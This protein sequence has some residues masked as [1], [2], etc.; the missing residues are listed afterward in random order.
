MKRQLKMKDLIVENAIKQALS[1]KEINHELN[2]KLGL[3]TFNF[4]NPLFT[5]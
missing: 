3:P 4:V 1:I 2:K 5:S